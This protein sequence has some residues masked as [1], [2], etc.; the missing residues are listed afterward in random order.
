LGGSGG[1][2]GGVHLGVIFAIFE[3][4]YHLG[5]DFVGDFATF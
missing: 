1:G 2:P 5:W 3:R 4:F